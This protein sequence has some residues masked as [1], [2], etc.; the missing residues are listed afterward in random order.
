MKHLFSTILTIVVLMSGYADVCAQTIVKINWLGKTTL[1]NDQY[2]DITVPEFDGAFH[3]KQ[4]DYLPTYRL[5]LNE[6]IATF[7]LINEVYVPLEQGISITKLPSKTIEINKSTH[8]RKLVSDISILTIR[9]NSETGVLEKL[10]SFQYQYTVEITQAL[11]QKRTTSVKSVNSVL[12]NNDWYKMAFVGSGLY[13]IDYNYLNSLGIN[14]DNI[15]PQNIQIYGNGGGMLPQVNTDF[16]HQDLTENAIYV[17]GEEDAK[18]NNDDYLL[19]YVE[20]ANSWKY[21]SI[22]KLYSHTRNIYSDTTYYFLTISNSQKGARIQQKSEASG[23]TA[24]FNTFDA[25]EFHEAEEVNILKSGRQWYGEV[26]DQYTSSHTISFNIPNLS[27]DST[28]YIVS[29]VMGQS[30]APTSTNMF[31][32]AKINGNNLGSHTVP[33]SGNIPYTN[34][35][36]DSKQIFIANSSNFDYSSNISLNYTFNRGVEPTATGYINY[37]DIIAIRDLKLH[38]NYVA[39]RNA[40]TTSNSVSKY[41][42]QNPSAGMMIWN[43]SNPLI[44]TNQLYTN[45]TDGTVSFQF[46]SNTLQEF[47]AFSG[48]TFPTPLAAT[49]I[50]NQNLRA[51]TSTNLLII[52]H[53]TFVAQAERLAK[54]RREHDSLSVSIVLVNDIY[55]EFSSGA[56]DITAIRDYV[57]FIYDKGYGTKDSLQYLLLFGACSYDYKN[58]IKNNTNYVPVYE[59]F[60][61]LHAVSSQSSDD[62]YGFLEDGDGRWAESPTDLHKVS[63][64]IGRIP[65]RTVSEAEN[66]VNKLYIYADQ[67]KSVG[68]WRNKISFIADA[69]DANLHV[70]QADKLAATIESKYK[71]MNVEK[72]YLDAYQFITFPDGVKAPDANKQIDNTVNKGALIVNYTGHGSETQLSTKKVITIPQIQSWTSINN[73]PFFVTA[74]CEVSR[75]DDPERFSAGEIML[76]TPDGGGIGLLTSSRPVFSSSNSALNTALYKILFNKKANGQYYRI[77]DIMEYTKNNSIIGIDNRN[78]AILGDPSMRLNYPDKQIALDSIMNNGTY[79]AITKDIDT[80]KALEKISIKG[81]LRDI[82]NSVMSSFNGT[83]FITYF[84]KP[85]KLSTLG[86][87]SGTAKFNFTTFGSLIYEGLATVNNGKFEFSFIVP[88]DISYQ[89]DYGKISVYAT[90]NNFKTDAA[91]YNFDMMVGGTNTNA[92]SDNTP[93]KVNLFMNDET[94]VQGGTTNNTPLLIANLSDDNGINITGAGV[95]H[96]LTAVLDNNTANVIVLNKYYT[97]KKDNYKEGRVEYRLPTLSPGLH[98]LKIKAWDTYNNSGENTIEFVVANSEK[99][100]LNHVLNYPNPFT[101]NTTFHFDHNKA[102]EDLSVQV[103]VFTPSGR[104]IKTL[105]TEITT[106]NSHFSNLT[107]DGKD[108]FG[109]N[110]GKGVYV[111]KIKVASKS[112]GSVVHR[113]EKLVI[114]N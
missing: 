83:V 40:K 103:Q 86:Q 96:E 55:N 4:F 110:I 67:S 95:G 14:P 102:G 66:A 39:F 63:I 24:T 79:K 75:Y 105:E 76:L 30:L 29:A 2:K 89:L 57:K 53:P 94:F 73:L 46:E 50:K 61:S 20:D 17:K 25:R 44:P 58:R 16:R 13:K 91:G 113:Y 27:K 111:Y 90:D 84:D 64:G 70:Q 51:N 98:T 85:S 42:I 7:K 112:D 48:S 43:I 88:K 28:I 72:I 12:A 71:N 49:K 41:V 54:L 107:W 33:A 26:F 31:F 106:S 65:A 23:A 68:K 74:T 47:I 32:T 81:S 18:F 38:N 92:A 10:S 9:R 45:E 56:Q 11:T 15:N 62:Y 5:S 109:D 80:T 77:G 99:I 97:S 37:I 59:M 35:G 82:D 21:D 104:L 6:N 22:S 101:T 8:Q 19:F 34:L 114:L 60:N 69:G 1:K 36:V 108:D 3:E 78:Y 93:P 87:E 52:T 100:V